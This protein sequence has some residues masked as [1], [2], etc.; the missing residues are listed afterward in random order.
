VIRTGRFY[1]KG[2]IAGPALVLSDPLSFWGGVDVATGRIIDRSHPDLGKSV[3]GHILLMPGGRGSSSSSSVFAEAIRRRTGPLG[4]LLARPDAI[5]TVGSMVAQSL[6]ELRCP[7]VVCSIEGVA[8]GDHI[9]ISAL[10]TG[11]ARVCILS[12]GDQVS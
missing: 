9:R 7:I 1:V 5:L 2:E 12:A 6:Y 10:D 3:A 4:I 11:A 8:D